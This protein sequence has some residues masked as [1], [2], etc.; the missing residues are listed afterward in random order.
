MREIRFILFHSQSL[1]TLFGTFCLGLDDYLDFLKK[2]KE[3]YGMPGSLEPFIHT[4]F[5]PTRA[6][7][8]LLIPSL[9]QYL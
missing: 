2:L 5:Y 9:Y 7:R 8:T 3:R 1:I 6:Y 4:Q